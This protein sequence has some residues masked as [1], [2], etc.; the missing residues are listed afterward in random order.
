MAW[1]LSILFLVTSK[2]W[3]DFE[4]SGLENPLA[5]LCLATLLALT[6]EGSRAVG[7]RWTWLAAALLI[8]T[9]Q[10]LAILALPAVAASALA[11]LGSQP[12]VHGKA[13][14][15]A[16]FREM[17]PGLAVLLAWHGFSLF[18]YGF[19]FPN[20]AYAKLSTGLPRPVL[21]QQGLAHFL[22]SLLWDPLSFGLCGVASMLLLRPGRPSTHRAW[23]AGILLHL[24]YVAWIGGDFMS[25]R[26]FVPAV[27]VAALACRDS[28]LPG[29]VR[30]SESSWRSRWSM[31]GT[32]GPPLR[33]V[34]FPAE[35]S[36]RAPSTPPDS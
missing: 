21:L 19:P 10:D 8:L 6:L 3:V 14:L 22:N 2:A 33:E 25:G 11:R 13:R 12:H 23:G 4:V 36:S 20:T 1:S 7:P 9:R 27:T 30:L 34:F 26:F 5:N 32:R 31:R 35:Q 15:A 24:A 17:L 28:C 29:P 16:V 18:Y